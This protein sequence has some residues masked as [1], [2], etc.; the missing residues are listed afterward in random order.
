VSRFSHGEL[1]AEAVSEAANGN[2]YIVLWNEAVLYNESTQTPI[3]MTPSP[4]T[5]HFGHAFS[6]VNVYDAF[7]HPLNQHCLIP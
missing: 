7:R 6:I 5:A 4:V 3:T 2:F 1:Q